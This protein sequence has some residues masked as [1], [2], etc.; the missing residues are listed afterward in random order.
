M[1]KYLVTGGAGFLGRSLVKK[2]LYLGHQVRVFDDLSRGNKTDLFEE[3]K[4]LE[5]SEGDIRNLD[6][7]IAA[8]KQVD[9][10]C[11][12]AYING[13]EF[14][15]SKPELVLDVG[16]KGMVNVLEACQICGVRELL[17]M[18]SS[19]VYQRASIV[20]TD[21]TVHLSIPDPHNPR[22]SYGGGKIISELMAI[23]FGRKLFK[24]VIIVRPH[25]VYGPNMGWEHVLPQ[26]IV[27]LARPKSNDGSCDPVEFPIKG[28]GQ[29]TRAFVYIDDFTEGV[30]LALEKGEHLGIYHVGSQEERS[31]ESVAHEVARCLGMK[32]KIKPGES[33]EGETDRR[34]PKIDKIMA[35]G[36][37]PKISFSEGVSHTVQW[38]LNNMERSPHGKA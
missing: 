14:F 20:P 19:E 1:K 22:Y 26:F 33:Y 37:R 18:S 35:L 21:E 31:I 23:N 27:R 2:L 34:C 36:Y 30:A 4:N 5:F 13:T 16:V 17:L 38:Y 32:I 10:V 25:N 8:T 29:Q 7:V 12:L 3:S 28:S 9:G 15:Y 24:K 6:S 11:H